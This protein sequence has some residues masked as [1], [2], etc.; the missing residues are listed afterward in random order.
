MATPRYRAQDFPVGS[1][2]IIGPV[3]TTRD[4]PF[5]Y[6]VTTVIGVEGVEVEVAP[7]GKFRL[8]DGNNGGGCVIKP[9]YPDHLQELQ[10]ERDQYYIAKQFKEETN[11]CLLPAHELRLLDAA[12]REVFRRS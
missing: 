2:V 6:I 12:V 8:R 7:A 9:A 3:K 4:Q 5:K 11:W 10:D 1:Q